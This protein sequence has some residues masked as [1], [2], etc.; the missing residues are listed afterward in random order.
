MTNLICHLAEFGE[1]LTQSHKVLK[2]N[3]KNFA[4]WCLCVKNLDLKHINEL[5]MLCTSDPIGVK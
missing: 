5:L 1:F 3:I 2:K 4:S